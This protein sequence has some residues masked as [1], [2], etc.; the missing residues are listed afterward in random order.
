MTRIVAGRYGGR[1]LLTPA[2]TNTRPTS[3]RVR[4]AVFSRLDHLGVL[5]GARVLDLYAGAGSLGLEAASRG[6]AEVVLVDVAKA[7]T[8]VAA[9]NVAA[10]GVP[11]VRVVTADAARF[12]AQ[13]PLG[14]HECPGYD[15]VLL[16][17]PYDL[18]EH[19]L[20]GLLA[21]LAQPGRLEPGALVVVERASRSPEPTW[22][23]AWGKVTSKRYGETAMWYAEV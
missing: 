15:L 9:K 20:S 18:P 17:P 8:A 5:T 12:L 6:A 10:L 13:P 22:P 2:G 7:A 4:E 16:D 11:G 14:G 1:R 21:A 23:S 19:D 3:E